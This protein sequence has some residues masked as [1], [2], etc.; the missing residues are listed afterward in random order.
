VPIRYYSKTEDP[1]GTRRESHD[2]GIVIFLGMYFT[3]IVV[4]IVAL[5]VKEFTTPIEARRYEL[6]YEGQ[7]IKCKVQFP[8]YADGKMSRWS[9]TVNLTQCENGKDYLGATNVQV[10]KYPDCKC[11][12]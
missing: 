11:G 5:V 8:H 7:I 10:L 4:G 9:G 2:I 12:G 6:L 1:V 3:L